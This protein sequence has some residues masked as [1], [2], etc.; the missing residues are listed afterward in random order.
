MSDHRKGTAVAA[1]LT[2]DEG[3]TRPLRFGAAAGRQV[4]GIVLVGAF[5]WALRDRLAMLDGAAVMAALARVDI[6]HWALALAATFVSF[7]ALAQYDAIIHRLLGTG[8]AARPARRA[9]WTSIALS[10]TIGFGLVSG[11]LVRWRM[12]PETSLARATKITATVAA[13]FLI[14]WAVLTAHVLLIAPVSLPGLSLATVQG[15]ALLGLALGGALALAAL[16]LPGLKI[17]RLTLRLP[18]PAVMAQILALALIDTAFAAL[19]LWALLPSGTDIGLLALFPAFLLALG[20]GFVSGTPGGVGPFEITLISL[21]P[22]APEPELLAAILA[23]RIAYFG[24]PALAAMAVVALRPAR[25]GDAPQVVAAP[26]DCPQIS[27]LVAQDRQAELGL[28]HQGNLGVLRCDRAPGGWMAGRAGQTLVALLEPFGTA[29]SGGM[30]NALREAARAEGRRASLYKVSG[31]TAALARKAG[32][33]VA[34]VATEVWLDPRSYTLDCPSRSGLRRKLRKAAKAGLTITPAEGPLPM[35]EMIA[36]A[37]HWRGARGGERGFS[38]GRFA[39]DYVRQQQV[40]LAH[41]KGKL[42]GFASFH[43]N[44]TEWVLDL[45]RPGEDAPDGTMQALINGALEAA[46]QAGV[47]RLS[48]AALPPRAE[49]IS[50]PA[51]HIWRR[52]EKGAGAA[53]LR[54]F[55][56]SFAPN[57]SPRYIA[58]PSAPALALAGVEIARAIHRPAPLAAHETAPTPALEMVRNLWRASRSS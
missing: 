17:G 15:F 8:T 22:S 51:A 54:Q 37:D 49:D 35:A 32:W 3:A 30:F 46:A 23:W 2:S 20:A 43:A 38:M 50:G 21:L 26:M 24:V 31:R 45:M 40:M 7:A 36:I 14:S 58:A 12:L 13:T 10:Q 47:K 16:L 19:A 42:V 5:L 53:G 1:Q 55:K 29:P 25:A 4:L 33:V 41:V 48:L 28:M 39:P 18:A 52:A 34:P 9:G 56:M 11:A 57:L 44:R 27:H 6:A